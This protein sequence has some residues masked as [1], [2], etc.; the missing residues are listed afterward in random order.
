MEILAIGGA[1]M[2][3]AFAILALCRIHMLSGAARVLIT[4]LIAAA[5]A[6]IG[7]AYWGQYTV[8]GHRAF[9]E[10]DAL[11]PFAAG[12]LGLVLTIVAALTAWWAG[13]RAK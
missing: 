11:Y 5:V 1:M 8:A 13:R 2:A 3:A 9:D 12:V 6:L 10:M 4:F 7:F